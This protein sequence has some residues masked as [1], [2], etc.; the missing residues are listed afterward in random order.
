MHKRYTKHNEHKE[1]NT[2]EILKRDG[3]H[4][5]FDANKIKEA[6]RRAFVSTGHTILDDEL[7]SITDEISSFVIQSET[8]T[9][10]EYIQDKVEETLMQHQYFKEAKSYILYRQ[11]SSENRGLLH[12]FIRELKDEEIIHVMI[13]I[14]KDFPE[15]VYDMKQLLVKFQTFLKEEMSGEERLKCL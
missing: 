5:T 14:Q 15:E 3:T 11:K 9:G 6:I 10:V 12:E 7:S 4:Q 8:L 1:G 13:G 2:M